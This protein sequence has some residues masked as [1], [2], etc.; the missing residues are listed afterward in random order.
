MSDVISVQLAISKLHVQNLAG[1]QASEAVAAQALAE[2]NTVLAVLE[3]TTTELGQQNGKLAQLQLAHDTEA[4][5]SRELTEQIPIAYVVTDNWGVIATANHGAEDLLNVQRDTLRGKPI[6]VFVPPAERRAFRER[7]NKLTQTSH[8]EVVIQPR[9]RQRTTIDIDVRPIPVA[10]GAHIQL[11]W[12]L[13]D[14]M[15][16]RAA[17]V[18]EKR[19]AREVKLRM[20]T[21]T[22]V[23]GLRALHAGLEA[24][25][26][27]SILPRRGRVTRMLQQLVPRFARSMSCDVP[28]ELPLDVGEK[29]GT[30]HV[31][32]TL[33]AHTN[34][35]LLVARR[36]LPFTTEDAAILLAG[37]NA[38]ALLFVRN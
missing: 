35:G 28:S 24:I 38:I 23:T 8:W 30:D 4:A 32:Q 20:E 11:G 14:L 13:Q 34:G 15:P 5:R 9:G 19:L 29:L 33:I 12:M 6:S 10:S 18:A 26:Q 7:L 37:S 25:T 16:L 36:S 27:E 1:Q 31:I 2:L 3:A 17:E 21:Q 22:A